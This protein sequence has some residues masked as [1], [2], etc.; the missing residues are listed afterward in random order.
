MYE[1]FSFTDNIF[2]TKPLKLR[3]T[4]LKKFIF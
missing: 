4:D 2:N 1:N 3:E